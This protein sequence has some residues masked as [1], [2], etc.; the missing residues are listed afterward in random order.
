MGYIPNDLVLLCLGQEFPNEDKK[1]LL[2]HTAH[3][4][5]RLYPEGPEV[6]ISKGK[7]SQK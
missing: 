6:A 1:P 5:L 7:I 3:N 2:L 4:R